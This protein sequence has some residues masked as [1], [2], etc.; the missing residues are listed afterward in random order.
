MLFLQV[1]W[2]FSSLSKFFISTYTFRVSTV[3]WIN[4]FWFSK[5]ESTVF[6]EFFD[7]YLWRNCIISGIYFVDI[8]ISMSYHFWL[9]NNTPRSTPTG[10][11]GED[12]LY[13]DLQ[14]RSRYHFLF[15]IF[16]KLNLSLFIVIETNF[17]YTRIYI[18]GV[19]RVNF[20]SI[21]G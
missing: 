12:K 18:F 1:I 7:V 13:D 14:G 19:P 6:R 4:T 2:S 15:L 17:Y 20:F 10:A 11:N 3:V 5:W 16:C 21:L 8:D 9:R